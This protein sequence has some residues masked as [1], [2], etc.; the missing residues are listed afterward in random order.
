MSV[1]KADPNMSIIVIVMKNRVG[2]FSTGIN[3]S[4]GTFVHQ[5]R[6]KKNPSSVDKIY[7]ERKLTRACSFRKPP[8]NIF[9]REEK[10][11][12]PSHT[13]E[14]DVKCHEARACIDKCNA[15][16]QECPTNFFL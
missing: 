9:Y 15:E 7:I 6:S 1:K 4:K 16:S 10:K 3:N 2:P 8:K 14:K 13:R 12:R 11:N 5:W